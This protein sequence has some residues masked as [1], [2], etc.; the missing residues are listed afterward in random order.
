MRSQ[1]RQI[2]QSILR[3][4]LACQDKFAILDRIH[5]EARMI[6]TCF[7]S[8]T[9]S[10]MLHYKTSWLINIDKNDQQLRFSLNLSPLNPTKIEAKIVSSAAG[11]IRQARTLISC[12]F[13]SVSGFFWVG[14]REFSSRFHTFSAWVGCCWDPCLEFQPVVNVLVTKC[15]VRFVDIVNDN[16]VFI[17]RGLLENDNTSAY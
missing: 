9:T 10:L 3:Y 1:V 8:Q 7:L 2:D 17:F 12:F 6:R 11:T 4:A 5:D 16:L 13:E 15:Y 14:F